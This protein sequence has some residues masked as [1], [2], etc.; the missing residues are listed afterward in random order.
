MEIDEDV[1]AAL[2]CLTTLL[3]GTH[4]ATPDELEDVIAQAGLTLGWELSAHLITFDQRRL[5]P[6]AAGR[7]GLDLDSPAGRAFR[8]M[9]PVHDGDIS[10]VPLLDGVERLGALRAVGLREGRRPSTHDETLRWVSLLVGHL[11]AVT[12][13]YGDNITVTR[14]GA[15]RTV[16]AELLWNLLPP[17]TYASTDVVIAGLLEP[18]EEVAGDA[19]DYAVEGSRVDLA[20]FDGTGHDLT[21]GL[22]ASVALATYRNQRRRGRDL[23]GCAGEIDRMLLE[24]T[25]SAGYATGILA[26]LDTVT[27]VL[28]YVNAGH[29]HPL[30]LRDGTVREAALDHTGRP[31]FGLGGREATAGQLQLEPG[32]T[33]VMYTDGITEAR[34]T[35][36]GF[37]GLPRLVALLE[38]HAGARTPAPELLRLVI[39]DVLDHQHDVLQDDATLL[40]LQWAPGGGLDLLPA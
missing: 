19:F 15:T 10:W 25:D 33:V 23:V 5:V 1:S 37:F 40:L 11:I 9:R 16:E 3:D 8:T 21:S 36:G 29:P 12:T 24:Q 20:L 32:D 26:R 28:D 27:G 30:L 22:L 39:R 35:D 13:P 34:D 18:S 17:L 4:R 7:D 31:L 6:L 14:G 2:R 38:E